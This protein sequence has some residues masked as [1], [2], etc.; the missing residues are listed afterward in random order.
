MLDETTAE[1]AGV[2]EVKVDKKEANKKER[3]EQMN[4]LLKDT[5]T[6]D[7]TFVK[8]LKSLSGGIAVVNTLGYGDSGTLVFDKKATEAKIKAGEKG[9][10][11]RDPRVVVPTSIVVGYRV[12]NIGD[13][14]IKYITEE[15]SANKE[16]EFVGKRV[17]KTLEPGGTAD[18]ARKYM[19]M[20][21][22]QPEISFR[23]SNGKIVRGP[24]NVPSGD[25]DGE[26][27]AHYFTFDP[28]T[29]LKVNSDEV[30]LN[31]STKKKDGKGQTRW[32]VKPE[33]E[34]AFGYLNNVKVAETRSTRRKGKFSSLDAAANLIHR[35]SQETGRI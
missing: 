26:L 9:K 8:R 18:L 35:L 10:D 24:A 5:I 14:P 23:L 16:G 3:L 2:E 1:V 27:E 20:F 28:K 31:I 33:F 7:P 19:T 13:T 34:K 15:F 11:G 30:K 12:S 32:V 25:V 4:E 22:A 17:E 6:N 29:G 21:C